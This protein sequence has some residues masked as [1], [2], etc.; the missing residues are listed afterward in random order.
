MPDPN[1][2]YVSTYHADANLHHI[3]RYIRDAQR[4]LDY[5]FPTVPEGLWP[6]LDAVRAALGDTLARI[7]DARLFVDANK[8]RLVFGADAPKTAEDTEPK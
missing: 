8:G 2:P 5:G 4:Q 3:G 1:Q 6:E 7:R